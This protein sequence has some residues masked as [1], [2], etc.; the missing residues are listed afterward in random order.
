M[1]SAHGISRHSIQ[2]VLAVAALA[3]LDGADVTKLS[4]TDVS[5][6]LLLDRGVRESV[7]ARQGW[8]RV[9]W[10]G[11]DVEATAPGTGRHVFSRRAGGDE[12]HPILP[13]LGQAHRYDCC[14]VFEGGAAAL[15]YTRFVPLRDEYSVDARLSLGGRHVTKSLQQSQKSRLVLN[16]LLLVR[17]G[18][19]R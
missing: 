8:A 10:G 6:A 3:A 14:V 1:Y 17:R 15:D 12:L 7:F 4:G 5:T 19:I 13:V 16:Q 11:G 9:G 18:L 2:G